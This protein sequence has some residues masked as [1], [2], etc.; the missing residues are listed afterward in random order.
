MISDF[1]ILK[2]S[3]VNSR[4]LQPMEKEVGNNER[5]EI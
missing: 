2:G 1:M 4:G 3:N 5:F